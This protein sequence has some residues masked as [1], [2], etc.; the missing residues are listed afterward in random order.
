[1]VTTPKEFI[2]S[3]RVGLIIFSLKAIRP[4]GPNP[5]QFWSVF[6]KLIFS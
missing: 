4:N 1:M 6:E 5:N 3:L 2:V